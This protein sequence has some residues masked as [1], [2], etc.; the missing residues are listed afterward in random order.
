MSTF[1]AK[2][3]TQAPSKSQL[4]PIENAPEVQPVVDAGAKSMLDN[5]LVP[6]ADLP[7]VPKGPT[8]TEVNA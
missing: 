2:E 4:K 3:M 7:I 8:T 1:V 6:L 5:K